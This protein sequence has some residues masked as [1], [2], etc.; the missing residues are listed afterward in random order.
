MV[1]FPAILTGLPRH[2]AVQSE[3]RISRG[4]LEKWKNRCYNHPKNYDFREEERLCS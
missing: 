2:T 4:M 3:G 1:E